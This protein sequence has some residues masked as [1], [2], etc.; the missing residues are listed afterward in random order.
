MPSFMIES[1][2]RSIA[3][4]PGMGLH[5]EVLSE[6]VE[7]EKGEKSTRLM[8][9]LRYLL[10]TGAND[11]VLTA[12][13]PPS[14]KIANSIKRLAIPALT[15]DDCMNYAREMLPDEGWQAF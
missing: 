1:A 10:K 3:A 6:L 4:N 9:L 14:I 2:I 15:P 8:P 5:G 11:M 13:A 7:M 12:G